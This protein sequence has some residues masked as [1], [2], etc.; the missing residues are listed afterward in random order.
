MPRKILLIDGDDK[1]L[2]S[3]EGMLRQL[4]Y[5]VVPAPSGTL[6]L[7]TAEAESPDLI[8]MDAELP[9]MEWTEVGRSLRTREVTQ[10]VPII[11]LTTR[12]GLDELVIGHESYVDDLLVKPFDAAELQQKLLPLLGRKANDKSKIIS[13]GSAELDDK[14]GGGIPLGSFSLIEGSSGAGKSVLV[15][16]LI[17]G[18]LQGGSRLTLFTSENTVRSLVKQ[19]QSLSLEILDFLLLGRLRIYPMELARLGKEAPDSLLKA[20]QAEANRDMIFVDALTAAIGRSADEDVISFFEGAKRL[21]SR[22]TTVVLVLH[23]HAVGKDLLIRL[24][25]LCDAHLQL[26]TEEMGQR[27][28]RT[29]EVTKIRGANKTTGN[30]V[31]FEVEPGWGMRL[32]PISRVKG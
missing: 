23:S 20:M 28:V 9:D 2:Q 30:L 17:W 22:G 31:S 5:E 13:T 15:Q 19:M 29:L 27:L 32:V 24:R 10:G 6:G 12:D 16:Q 8:V 18:S 4:E 11:L 3:I 25:S 7:T 1:S 26:Y 14:M 21:C